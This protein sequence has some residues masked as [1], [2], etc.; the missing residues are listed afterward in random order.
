M[1]GYTE[2]GC[3]VDSNGSPVS[4]V[5]KISNVINT[6]AQSA[7]VMYD[8][9]LNN[10]QYQ[11]GS[12]ISVNANSSLATAREIPLG[13]TDQIVFRYKSTSDTAYQFTPEKSGSRLWKHS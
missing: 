6:G 12:V 9:K 8:Y 11:S 4:P 1:S 5:G 3:D 2:I 13:S 10:G 7:S